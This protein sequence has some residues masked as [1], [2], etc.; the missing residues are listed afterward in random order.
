MNEFPLGYFQ[1]LNMGMIYI[2]NFIKLKEQFWNL[3]AIAFYTIN[4]L[5]DML[6]FSYY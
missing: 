1:K 6:I 3:K 4:G 5:R 2:W